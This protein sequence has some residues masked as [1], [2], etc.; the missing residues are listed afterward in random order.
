MHPNTSHNTIKE[1]DFKRSN[2]KISPSNREKIQPSAPPIETIITMYPDICDNTRD[3]GEAVPCTKTKHIGEQIPQ[4]YVYVEYYMPVQTDRFGN[5]IFGNLPNYHQVISVKD[6]KSN[7]PSDPVQTSPYTEKQTIRHCCGKNGVLH[8]CGKL[9]CCPLVALWSCFNGICLVLMKILDFF[10]KIFSDGWYLRML[11]YD[12]RGIQLIFNIEGE[13]PNCPLMP[14]GYMLAT[15]IFVL[16]DVIIGSCMIAIG[17]IGSIISIAIWV[18]F[19]NTNN[20]THPLEI[21]I[22]FFIRGIVRVFIEIPIYVFLLICCFCCITTEDLGC[23]YSLSS[24]TNMSFQSFVHVDFKMRSLIKIL[25]SI[26][27]FSYTDFLTHGHNLATMLLTVPFINVIIG[28]VQFIVGII[29]LPITAFLTIFIKTKSISWLEWSWLNILFGLYGMSLFGVFI[30]Q[31]PPTCCSK[32]NYI[33]GIIP[34]S[35][36][37][38]S[39]F[40]LNRLTILDRN[41]MSFS[42]LNA[43]K[44]GGFSLRKWSEFKEMF[45]PFS[46]G[47]LY[48]KNDR[49]NAMDCMSMIPIIGI[50][51]FIFRILYIVVLPYAIFNTIFC[52]RTTISLL[53]ECLL[54]LLTGFLAGSVVF[55]WGNMLIH[56]YR[57]QIV[58]KEHRYEENADSNPI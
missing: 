56:S 4:K 16:L 34:S 38:A 41:S 45:N 43:V 10:G 30:V 31:N 50:V 6:E 55:T 32:E 18:F 35:S 28:S 23:A 11:K 19:E 33:D 58:P 20:G 21:S 15:P 47:Y 25:K 46:V 37:Y 39:L 52:K 24:N 42:Q 22:H 26:N 13:N 17:I 36:I 1:D 2:V 40:S 7:A 57:F 14:F 51:P 48:S 5:A 44:T 9:I 27:I 54:G 3:P 49:L 53:K 12:I 29:T 8:Y